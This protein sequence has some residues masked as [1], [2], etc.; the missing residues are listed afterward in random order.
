MASTVLTFRVTLHAPEGFSAE[1]P[2]Q[3][4]EQQILK[5]LNQPL[6]LLRWAIVDIEGPQLTCEGAYLTTP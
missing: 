4:L 1:T 2:A 6:K 5:Q 3:V